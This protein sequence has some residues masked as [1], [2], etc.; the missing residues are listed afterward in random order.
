M[1]DIRAIANEDGADGTVRVSYFWERLRVLLL[2]W[3]LS[4]W[5]ILHRSLV[6][7]HPAQT[8]MIVV[9]CSPR[10]RCN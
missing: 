10:R 5:E 3:A 4:D 2:I 1:G 6:F 8:H 9:V 7:G